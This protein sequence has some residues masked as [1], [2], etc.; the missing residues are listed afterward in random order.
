MPAKINIG[1]AVG[2]KRPD[3]FHE[4]HTVFAG[5]DLFDTVTV[6]AADRLSLELTGTEAGGLPTDQ[7]NLAWQAAEKL[8]A[9]VRLHIDKQ[10]PVAA[11][12]AGGS[13]DAAGVLLGCHRLQ[14]GPALGPV[15]T[16]LGSDVAFALH[17]G[18]A[19]GRGRGEQLEPLDGPPLHWVL[20]AATGEL[21]TP[22]VYAEL[23]RIRPTA[24]EPELDPDLITAVSRGDAGTLAG[25]LSNDLQPAAINL[26]PYLADTL[27]AGDA[28]GALAGLVSGS[29][30]T[31]LFLA[32]DAEHATALAGRLDTAG[33][34]TRAVTTGARST[35]ET[36]H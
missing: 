8:Q 1:L 20:V 18:L 19:V 15:A 34:F 29:G 21:S 31:C 6:A 16:E 32:A 30:P 26:A 10:I 27:A 23:D 25:K 33:R 13:A 14:P 22:A 12:L 35:I 9:R 36:V 28:A 2:P 4:L 17:G 7:S 5:I 11:G 3:G 24:D